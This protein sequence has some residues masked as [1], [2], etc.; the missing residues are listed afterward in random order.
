[1][2]TRG[3][4]K[5]LNGT[6]LILDDHVNHK[7][8]FRIDFEL[9]RSFR[10]TLFPKP[11]TGQELFFS[12]RYNKPALGTNSKALHI[13]WLL[14][15]LHSQIDIQMITQLM[16]HKVTVLYEVIFFKNV[17]LLSGKRFPFEGLEVTTR[18]RLW[19]ESLTLYTYFFFSV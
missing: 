10:G 16:F 12:T 4:L 7:D 9:F 13:Y 11:V 17:Y 14:K 1:M 8:S 2:E 6:K 3:P 19:L 18:V 15:Y 5:I